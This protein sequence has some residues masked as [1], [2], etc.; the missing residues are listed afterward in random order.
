MDAV[1]LY[2]REPGLDK[3]MDLQKKPALLLR[4][5]ELIMALK[6]GSLLVRGLE[7]EVGFV[8]KW[9]SFALI[10]RHPNIFHVSG[11][12]TSRGPIAVTLTEKDRN[13]SSEETLA[14]ELMEP[15]LVRNLRIDGLPDTY[16][17][18]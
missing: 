4:L 2:H 12:S 7:K 16:G 5:R 13:I 17:E 14:Q 11:G 18:D 6:S 10:E 8:Q 15:I 3:A 1:Q 9:N